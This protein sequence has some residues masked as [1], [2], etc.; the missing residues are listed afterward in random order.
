MLVIVIGT[1]LVFFAYFSIFQILFHSMIYFHNKNVNKYFLNR[2]NE[3]EYLKP[4]FKVITY[5]KFE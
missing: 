5:V 2:K 4:N 1:W 3:Y